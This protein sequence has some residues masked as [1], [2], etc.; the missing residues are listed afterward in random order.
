MQRRSRLPT[1]C[2][3]Q[4][5]GTA[6]VLNSWQCRTDTWNR[7]QAAAFAIRRMGLALLRLNRGRSRFAVFRN[8]RRLSMKRCMEDRRAGMQ[9]WSTA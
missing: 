3:S 6:P 7:H 1:I 4:E 5:V 2:A 8:W 9:D